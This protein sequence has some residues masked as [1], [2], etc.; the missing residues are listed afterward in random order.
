MVP[1]VCLCPFGTGGEG[2]L[3]PCT[4]ISECCFNTIELWCRT[5]YGT[6]SLGEC[7]LYFS[8]YLI[9]DVYSGQG[10]IGFNVYFMFVVHLSV[11]F[12]LSSC[13]IM[14]CWAKISQKW[15]QYIQYCQFWCTLCSFHGML[16]LTD[17]LVYELNFYIE[18]I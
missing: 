1:N 6:T 9:V 5:I 4:K 16:Q 18:L 2:H 12:L 11:K 3:C 7:W 10:N 17:L 15:H 14:V 8:L 13:C